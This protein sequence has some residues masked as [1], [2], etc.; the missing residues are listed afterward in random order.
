[1]EETHLPLQTFLQKPRIQ[2]KKHLQYYLH[3]SLFRTF[4]HLP[5]WK[6]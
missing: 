3:E 2:V 5:K 6:D 1:M 4:L